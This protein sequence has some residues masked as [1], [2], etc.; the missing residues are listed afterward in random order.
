[1]HRQRRTLRIARGHIRRR[2]LINAL[3]EP[4]EAARRLPPGLRPHR[5]EG[6]TVVG[7][8]LLDIDA[9]RP[10]G[11]PEALGRPLR[12]AAHRIAVDWTTGDG[13]VVTGVYVPARHTDAGA[14]IVLGGRWIPG[15]HRAA[16]IAITE[17][18]GRLRWSSAPRDECF[19]LEVA[20]ALPDAAA[21]AVTEDAVGA[22]CLGATLGA[23]PGRTGATEVAR[24]QLAH[25]DA[26]PVVVDTIRSRFLEGFASARITTSYLQRDVVV[27]FGRDGATPRDERKSPCCS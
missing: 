14:A 22:V 11:L 23:S 17:E 13:R 7:C 24:M 5:T 1:M 4:A 25:R 15:V 6:G 21:A 3:V 16:R 12:A 18:A 20:V 26:C 9:M 27:R 10:D 19:A 8:C 2:L